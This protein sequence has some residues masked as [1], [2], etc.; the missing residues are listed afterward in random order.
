MPDRDEL[1]KKGARQ[2]RR[3]RLLLANSSLVL[4]TNG[5]VIIW[6][7]RQG[8]HFWVVLLLVLWLSLLVSTFRLWRW[9][10]RLQR[11]HEELERQGK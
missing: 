5:A 11:L 1:L 10:Q 6:L 3:G 8:E 9:H 7:F 4:G 2:L